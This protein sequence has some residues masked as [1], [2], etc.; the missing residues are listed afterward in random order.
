VL[1]NVNRTL[2]TLVPNFAN[3]RAGLYW[4]TTVQV[5]WTDILSKKVFEYALDQNLWEQHELTRL[6]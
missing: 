3:T 6:R 5:I 4:H 2:L 1:H